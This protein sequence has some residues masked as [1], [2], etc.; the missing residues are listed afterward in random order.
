MN[1]VNELENEL[2]VALL[3]EKKHFEKFDYENARTL[4]A[5]VKKILQTVSADARMR[6]RSVSTGKYKNFFAH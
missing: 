2:V 3:V 5:D 1:L 4:I 6:D